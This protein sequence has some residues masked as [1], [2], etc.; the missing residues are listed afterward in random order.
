MKSEE[1]HRLESNWLATNA[2][3]WGEKL[4]PYSS[5]IL[6]AIAAV[7]GLYAVLSFW[8]SRGAAREEQ[9]WNDYEMALLSPDMD[10]RG[11]YRVA[12]NEELAGTRMQDW[13]YV[14]WADRQL[15]LAVQN[16]LID[17]DAVKERLAEIKAIYDLY[18]TQAIE[19]EVK[20]RA[21]FGL[22]RVNE[23]QNNFDEAREHYAQVQGALQPVAA[24]RLKE[25]E[26]HKEEMSEVGTW[27]ATAPLPRPAMPASGGTPGARPS[28]DAPLPSTPTGMG[29]EAFDPSDMFDE[30][31]GKSGADLPGSERYDAAGAADPAEDAATGDAT[32]PSADTPPTSDPAAPEAEAPPG[33]DAPAT[34]EAAPASDVIPAAETPATSAPTEPAAET[35]TSGDAAAQP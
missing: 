5:A 26:D 20:N 9:A 18:S 16:Y 25:L 13:A 31:L 22:A 10:Y 14:A 4:R 3:I 1:R 15:L 28:F 12:N 27:L 7:L 35:A 6:F 2:P 8:N 24:A 11:V 17:R 29:A 30:V 32:A 33:A 19:P 34:S 21:R 23:L